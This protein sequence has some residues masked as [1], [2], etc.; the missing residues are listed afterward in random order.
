MS[1]QASRDI[2]DEIVMGHKQNLHALSHK[3]H[4]GESYNR[5]PAAKIAAVIISWS[6][7]HRW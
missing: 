2:W 6:F 7:I 4:V 1:L 5:I 3:N